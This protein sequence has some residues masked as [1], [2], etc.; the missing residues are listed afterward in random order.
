MKKLHCLITIIILSIFL[1]ACG[2]DT[3]SN[4]TSS[5]NSSH[6]SDIITTEKPTE[7]IYSD[8]DIVAANFVCHI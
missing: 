5:E 7:E 6:G 3:S 2:N 1:S 8:L 4:D